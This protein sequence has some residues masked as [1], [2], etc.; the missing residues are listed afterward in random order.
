MLPDVATCLPFDL[1]FLFSAPQLDLTEDKK[2]SRLES[3][4]VEN[5]QQSESDL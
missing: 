5:N 2:L 3:S 4:T 1:P